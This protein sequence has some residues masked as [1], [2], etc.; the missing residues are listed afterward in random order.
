[1]P[2]PFYHRPEAK[3]V[4]EAMNRGNNTKHKTIRLI[5]IDEDGET[6]NEYLMEEDDYTGNYSFSIPPLTRKRSLYVRDNKWVTYI[7]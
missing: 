3:D 1:M 4:R 5:H 7:R 6:H 2:K